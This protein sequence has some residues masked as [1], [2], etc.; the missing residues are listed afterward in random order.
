MIC[1]LPSIKY[2]QLQYRSHNERITHDVPDAV[3]IFF[4]P[5]VCKKANFDDSGGK[6]AAGDVRSIRSAVKQCW[7]EGG[8]RRM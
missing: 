8:Q 2:P 5:V 6:A 3:P 1:K 7:N 4:L